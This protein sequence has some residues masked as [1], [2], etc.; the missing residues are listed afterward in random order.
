VVPADE[1][2]RLAAVI[3]AALTELP[4]RR[5][6]SDDERLQARDPTHAHARLQKTEQRA[7]EPL[8]HA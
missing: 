7:T 4:A 8:S 2:E 6:G 3:T 5:D 1:A